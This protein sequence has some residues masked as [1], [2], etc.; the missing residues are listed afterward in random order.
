[1]RRTCLA[2]IGIEQRA[3]VDW[4]VLF[5]SALVCVSVLDIHTH[6]H[7]YHPQLSRV[8]LPSVPF[9]F[10]FSRNAFVTIIN[11]LN[12]TM[13]VAPLP[14]EVLTLVF[15]QLDVKDLLCAALVNRA[16][17]AAVTA[18]QIL[19]HRHWEKLDHDPVK[20]RHT[21]VKEDVDWF[22]EGKQESGQR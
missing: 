10:S 3:S 22:A 11:T 12:T 4:T 18:R 21:L 14:P 19:L 7:T 6:A 20:R 5:A 1:M 8:D 17:R 9:S 15:E 13:A 16:W 2:T